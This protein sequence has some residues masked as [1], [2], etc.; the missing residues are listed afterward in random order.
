MLKFNPKSKGQ[1]VFGHS[2]FPAENHRTQN[3]TILIPTVVGKL[4]K[5]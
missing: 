4:E 2:D 1:C 3:R 5:K